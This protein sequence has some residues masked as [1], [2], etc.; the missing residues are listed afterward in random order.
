VGKMNIKNQMSIEI[1]APREKI[2]PFLTET[3]KT[4]QWYF[5][6]TKLEYVGEQHGGIGSI[7]HI[8]E[9]IGLSKLN[10]NCMITAYCEFE[11]VRLNMISGDA[12]F[13]AHIDQEWKIEPT[14][15]GSKF[16][17]NESINAKW[18]FIGHLLVILVK[19]IMRSNLRKMLIKL[20]NVAEGTN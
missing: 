4:L 7:L 14:L 13:M 1:A 18:G 16:I 19:P 5:E 20:K 8:E 9:S 17:F 10:I 11:M 6:L 12:V 15:A 2:W 3:N